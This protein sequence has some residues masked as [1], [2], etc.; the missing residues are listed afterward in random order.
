M[1]KVILSFFL[2]PVIIFPQRSRICI[3]QL[4][5][6]ENSVKAAVVISKEKIQAKYFDLCDALTDETIW[7]GDYFI[8]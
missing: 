5:Y 1:K 2:F 4:G 7:R 3:N 8:W 6:L